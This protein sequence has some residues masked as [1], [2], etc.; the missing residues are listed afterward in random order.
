VLRKG[1]EVSGCV[2]GKLVFGDSTIKGTMKHSNRGDKWRATEDPE[3][4]EEL[5][6][7]KRVRNTLRQLSASNRKTR[8]PPSSPVLSS[9]EQFN[10]E[11]IISG[12]PEKPGN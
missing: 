9:H 10:K 12:N 1:V 6:P 11:T 7:K 5:K 3:N 4:T 2:D 8:N